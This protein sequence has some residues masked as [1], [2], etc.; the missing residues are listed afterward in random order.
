[1]V[2]PAPRSDRAAIEHH[3]GDVEAHQ[4][5]HGARNRLVA[6]RE[7]HQGVELIA[8]GH[9]LDRVG[10]H[11]AADQRGLHPLGPHRDP[12]GDRDGVEL[13]WGAARCP[14]SFLDVLGE[15]AQM[16]VAR[17]CLGPGVRDPD[18]RPA[19]R[20]V[21]EPD[22][23][24]VGACGGAVG[25]VEDR[26]RA[27]GGAASSPRRRCRSSHL[28]R[29]SPNSTALL[30]WPALIG[31]PRSSVLRAHR[32]RESTMRSSATARAGRGL[33]GRGRDRPDGRE[34]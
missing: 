11:L 18:R 13:H 14:D 7:R 32:S 16:E 6:G 20:V 10:D 2:A 24:H 8:A 30:L 15:P 5:H 26:R 4:R 27:W 34:G 19:E 9:E 29:A 23:L 33:G 1:M 3:P 31:P 21:V 28:H 22:P 12:V 17:H 25:P